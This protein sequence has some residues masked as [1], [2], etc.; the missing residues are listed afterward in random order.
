MELLLGF[1]SSHAREEPVKRQP[2]P[3]PLPFDRERVLARW[4]SFLK[5]D[6]F[7]LIMRDLSTGRAWQSVRS[8]RLERDRPSARLRKS[9]RLFPRPLPG[10]YTR[11]LSIQWQIVRPNVETRSHRI[12]PGR[13]RHSKLRPRLRAPFSM[14]S[15][16]VRQKAHGDF[17]AGGFF[18]AGTTSCPFDH[19][20]GFHPTAR[21]SPN[22]LRWDPSPSLCTNLVVQVP[23]VAPGRITARS[24]SPSLGA[25]FLRRGRNPR[26]KKPRARLEAPVRVGVE[27]KCPGAGLTPSA[28]E[29]RS[30]RWLS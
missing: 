13:E 15:V 10:G 22:R 11:P 23:A 6:L 26:C 8:L 24:S 29:G 19:H 12:F 20:G 14:R 7:K 30:L 3:P 1:G 9:A 25:R 16:I 2:R 4:V 21:R 17:F 18:R 5:A 27:R 28:N